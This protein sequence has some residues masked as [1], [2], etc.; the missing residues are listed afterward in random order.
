MQYFGDFQRKAVVVV[1]C[2]KVYTTRLESQ[3]TKE[4][5]EVPDQT[6]LD[7]EGESCI[8]YKQANVKLVILILMQF[9]HLD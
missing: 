9:L 7:M 5:K 2:E 8:I 1:P 3:R 6:I 4:G